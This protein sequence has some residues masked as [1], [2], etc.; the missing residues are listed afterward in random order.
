MDLLIVHVPEGRFNR[1]ARLSMAAHCRRILRPWRPEPWC[2]KQHFHGWSILSGQASGFSQL[3]QHGPHSPDNKTGAA[4]DA[5]GL[6]FSS[7][8]NCSPRTDQRSATR[9]PRFLSRTPYRIETTFGQPVERYHV[10]RV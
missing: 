1:L 8:W 9:R 10:K 6:R 2:R 7:D 4:H 5:N 3:D